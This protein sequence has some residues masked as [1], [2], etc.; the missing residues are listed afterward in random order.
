MSAGP[1]ST[2]ARLQAV[3]GQLGWPGLTGLLML[4][5]TAW[6]V[7]QVL[8]ASQ[9]S[10]EDDEAQ[11]VHLRR[12]LLVLS[13]AAEARQR[14]QQAR[15]PVEDETTPAL[16]R[17]TW[18]RAWAALPTR[19]DAVARQGAVL[20]QAGTLGVVV[21]TVQYRGA[22]L[23]TLPSVW[24][25][26]MVLPVEAPYPALRSWLGAVLQDRAVSLDALDVVR[27]DPMGDQVK[28]RVAL[29]VWWREGAP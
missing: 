9:A 11:V 1:V 24:R 25:Q 16:V 19:A 15:L 29:S 22:A 28:A 27:T 8:P 23:N 18:A 26:Q 6:G 21:P 10:L 7:W 12:Q 5:V 13:Q 4:A 20:A 14:P 3:L 2:M 17:D